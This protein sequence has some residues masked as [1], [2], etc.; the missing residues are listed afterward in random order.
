SGNHVAPGKQ[1]IESKDAGAVRGNGVA[2]RSKHDE[3]VGG[4]LTRLSPLDES[5]DAAQ[6][7]GRARAVRPRRGKHAPS[8][9]APLRDA[10]PTIWLVSTAAESTDRSP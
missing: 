7:I 9:L 3:N 1:P 8:R 5:N 4:G 2:R 10:E 6:G